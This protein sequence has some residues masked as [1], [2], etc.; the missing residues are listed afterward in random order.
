MLENDFYLNQPQI[1]FGFH[2]C[3]KAIRDKILNSPK[4]HLKKSENPYDWLG[5]GIYFWLNDPVR[6][7]EWAMQQKKKEPAVIGAV[8]Q[9]GDCLNLCERSSVMYLTHAYEILHNELEKQGLTMKENRAP[10]A[11]GYMLLRDRDCAVIER[12]HFELEEKGVKGFDTVYGY[13]QEGKDAYPG[14]GIKEK[15]HIQICVRNV[16]CIKGYF[17]PREVEN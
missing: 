3:E 12:L 5:R 9:L 17:L 6:A 1:V 15:T 4:E 10:D 2:G 16:N 8:I 13:F 7:L 14:A 11:G